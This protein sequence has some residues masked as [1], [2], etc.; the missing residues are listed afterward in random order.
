MKKL[1]IGIVLFLRFCTFG[2]PIPWHTSEPMSLDIKAGVR[3][4]AGVESATFDSRWLLGADAEKVAFKIDVNGTELCQ[5]NGCGEVVWSSRRPGTYAFACQMY[6]DGVLSGDP[7]TATFVVAGRDL[8]R[9][10]ISF[11]REVALYDGGEQKP[12]PKVVL[13]GQVLTEGVDYSL[14]Y[15]DNVEPGV[16]KVVITG[17]GKY[18]DEIERTFKIV[19]AG[20]CA[21]DVRAGVR[22]TA[23]EEIL[24]YDSAWWWGGADA[25]RVSV[26]GRELG[27]N[28]GAG[29]VRW[30]PIA[31]GDY[32]LKLSA[33]AGGVVQE[34]Q[35]TAHFHVAGDNPLLSIELGS[36]AY[37]YAGD[38]VVPDVSVS[39]NGKRLV[40]NVDYEIEVYDNESAGSG[41]IAVHGLGEYAGTVTRQFRILPSAKCRLD[42]TSG[43]RIAQQEELIAY[44][45]TWNGD[46]ESVVKI[47]LNESEVVVDGTV[48]DYEW[49][50]SG[51][52]LYTFKHTTYAADGTI[53]GDE[54]SAEFYVP[55][56]MAGAE[57]ELSADACLSDGT[58][59]RPAVRVVLDGKVLTEGLDYTVEY[60]DNIVPGVGKVIVVG[61][62]GERY[63]KSFRILPAGKCFLDIASGVREAKSAEPLM[64]DGLWFGDAVADYKIFID[65]AEMFAGNGAGE[66]VWY[67]RAVGDHALLYRAYRGGAKA[68]DDLTATFHVGGQD[69]V[70]AEIAFKGGTVLYDGTP[71]TPE[72]AVT[73][74]GRTL[75]EG[76]D[77]EL[78]YRDNVEKGMGVVVITGKGEFVDIVEKTFEIRPAGVCS[79][80]IESGIRMAKPTEVLAYD[81]AW[82]GD[83]ADNTKMRILINDERVTEITGVGGYEWMPSEGGDY[84]VKLRT[85]VDDYLI[86]ETYVA[87]FGASGFLSVKSL[88][89]RQRYPWNGLIDIDYELGGT[90]SNC[91]YRMV[92]TATNTVDGTGFDLKHVFLKDQSAAADSVV[93]S[94][95]SGRLVWDAKKDLPKDF[96]TRG[97]ELYVDVEPVRKEVAK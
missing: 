22:E 4:S 43:V 13:D 35:E 72:V 86:D 81:Y 70:N 65:G 41:T 79:L 20:V 75:Q 48:G 76:V 57:V 6:E 59:Q 73:Y 3:T 37:I 12:H 8:V 7:L 80:D 46:E 40:R 29:S 78:S 64:H 2:A 31:A 33:Y 55:G 95:R 91:N 45:H 44:D 30:N 67:P 18:V 42:L 32:E 84:T 68:G 28:A 5:T 16:G 61:Q 89:V 63:E 88:H 62:R 24:A 50:P 85:Y 87:Y 1:F 36:T 52:G 47:R 38:P 21:L 25:T 56:S 92:F 94:D 17:L 90:V 53:S 11:E 71:R 60:A 15:E 96:R 54:L 14:S 49:R 39:Y 82:K 23:G 66:D 9:A 74:G 83:R 93:V 58:E 26:N 19:P 34:H 77:Y 27:E 69:L 51:V 97:M 10:E